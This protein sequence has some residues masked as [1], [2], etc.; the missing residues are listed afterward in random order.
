MVNHVG[1]A[2]DNIRSG[3]LS[4]RTRGG[5]ITHLV[6]FNEMQHQL[7]NYLRHSQ[8][9]DDWTIEDFLE[10]CYQKAV[11][12]GVEGHFSAALKSSLRAIT[13]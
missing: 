8:T 9:T 4:A 11:A 12:S 1:L 6:A 3:W 5:S 7:Y 13:R 10:G 2:N